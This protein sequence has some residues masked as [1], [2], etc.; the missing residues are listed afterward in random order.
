MIRGVS[1]CNRFFL[2]LFETLSCV[3]LESLLP[4]VILDFAVRSI[5]LYSQRNKCFMIP[6]PADTCQLP[7]THH[8]QLW[9]QMLP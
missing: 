1:Y 3:A 2:C 5:I 7:K 4:L 8:R 9:L 6:Q